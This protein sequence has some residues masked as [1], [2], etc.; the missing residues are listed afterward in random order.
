VACFTRSR[1]PGDERLLRLV[2]VLWRPRS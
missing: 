2:I 1:E